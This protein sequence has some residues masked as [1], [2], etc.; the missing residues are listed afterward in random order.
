M[1]MNYEDAFDNVI[2]SVEIF[3]EAAAREVDKHNLNYLL[4]DKALEMGLYPKVGGAH[5]ETVYV[6]DKDDVIIRFK[7]EK[8]SVFDYYLSGITTL[9]V[10]Q[11]GLICKRVLEMKKTYEVSFSIREKNLTGTLNI[12]AFDG[13]HA[14]EIAEDELPA[15]FKHEFTVNGVKLKEN[16]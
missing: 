6:N 16:K 3:T 4:K 10:M 7:N 1:N 8:D 15:Y 5:F 13:V 9:D 11:V 2:K 14:Q 12:E